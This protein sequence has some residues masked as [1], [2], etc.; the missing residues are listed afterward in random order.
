MTRG[1]ALALILGHA[2][3]QEREN[4]NLFFDKQLGISIERPPK[5]DEWEFKTPKSGGRGASFSVTHRAD[6]LS[7]GIL[8]LNVI[9]ANAYS[10]K[11]AAEDDWKSLSTDRDF[12]EM[13]KLDARQMKLPGAAAGGV[14]A[15][16]VDIVFKDRDGL[17]GEAQLWYFDSRTSSNFYKVFVIG[18]PGLRARHQKQVD[19][20]LSTIRTYK[21]P[22]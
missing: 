12:K 16:K 4:P 13:R 18:A 9:N 11:K 14:W 15:Y 6:D 10:P 17:S 8:T 7:I 21:L 19:L 5:G 1:L 22:K 20:I 2:A 3:S